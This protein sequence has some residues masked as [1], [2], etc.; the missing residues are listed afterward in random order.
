MS[1]SRPCGIL[2]CLSNADWV[3]CIRLRPTRVRSATFILHSSSP[4]L[5]TSQHFFVHFKRPRTINHEPFRLRPTRVS[6]SHV[7]SWRSHFCLLSF[8]QCPALIRTREFYIRFPFRLVYTAG[9][10]PNTHS[11]I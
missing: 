5:Y 6:S 9:V 11:G 3:L 2:M 4:P 8:T 1:L 7:P 10:R